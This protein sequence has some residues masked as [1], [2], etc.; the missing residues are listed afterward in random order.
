MRLIFT[1]QTVVLVVQSARCVSVS[2]HLFGR[3]LSNEM[4]FHVNISQGRS[5]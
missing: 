1:D 2:L 3:Q 5:T 4:T